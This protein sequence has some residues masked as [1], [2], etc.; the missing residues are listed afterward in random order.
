MV[1]STVTQVLTTL[2]ASFKIDETDWNTLPA[3]HHVIS[4]LAEIPVYAIVKAMVI[5]GESVSDVP[6]VR[7]I[8]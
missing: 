7:R 6:S 4:R 3:L 2:D 1:S 5:E 8:E